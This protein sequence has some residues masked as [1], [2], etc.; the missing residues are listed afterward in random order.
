MA[1]LHQ[2]PTCAVTSAILF[3]P[4]FLVGVVTPVGVYTVLQD[5]TGIGGMLVLVFCITLPFVFPIVVSMTSKLM[6][7][8]YDITERLN[9]ATSSKERAIIVCSALADAAL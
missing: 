2:V 3:V 1:K 5:P 8:R 6:G 9:T 4:L 7:R